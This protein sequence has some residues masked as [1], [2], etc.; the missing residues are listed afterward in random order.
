MCIKKFFI[1]C[2]EN[3]F[4]SFAINDLFVKDLCNYWQAKQ[5]TENQ[6][7]FEKAE[8][9]WKCKNVVKKQKKTHETEF[10]RKFLVKIKSLMKKLVFYNEC[11]W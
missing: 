11:I 9:S 4:E 5:H 3:N 10:V 2:F 6:K 1:I 7:P 8:T